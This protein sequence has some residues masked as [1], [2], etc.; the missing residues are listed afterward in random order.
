M[1]ILIESPLFPSRHC[2]PVCTWLPL[3]V[4]G[5]RSSIWGQATMIDG[6]DTVKWIAD[7]SP[8]HRRRRRGWSHVMCDCVRFVC[9]G[10]SSSRQRQ[11]DTRSQVSSVPTHIHLSSFNIPR[12][13]TL[14]C[15][16][17]TSGGLKKRQIKERKNVSDSHGH[18]SP[19]THFHQVCTRFALSA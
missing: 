11:G 7:K 4:L 2:L 10:K 19:P 3:I 16:M 9:I 15:L 18:T 5:S 13:L 14:L 1:A 12:I 6:S 8:G 17:R